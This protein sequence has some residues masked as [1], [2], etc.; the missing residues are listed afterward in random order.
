MYLYMK[1]PQGF[2]SSILSFS[3]RSIGP[4]PPS[5]ASRLA[6]TTGHQL[7]LGPR[8]PLKS[9]NLIP[10]DP[11]TVSQSLGWPSR[12]SETK[13]PAVEDCLWF[14]GV[15]SFRALESKGSRGFRVEHLVRVV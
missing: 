8:K 1:E 3:A 6:K 4:T 10:L 2:Q 11:Y 13:N 9:Q 15:K 7:L 12:K 14:E 5:M